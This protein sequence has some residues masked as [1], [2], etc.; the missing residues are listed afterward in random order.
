MILDQR[1]PCIVRGA[2]ALLLAAFTA[3]A[4]AGPARAAEAD[5]NAGYNDGKLG[6]PWGA[7][8]AVPV[9]SRQAEALAFR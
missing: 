1:F 8:A 7:G 4:R 5:L 6:L 2:M 9:P 3:F